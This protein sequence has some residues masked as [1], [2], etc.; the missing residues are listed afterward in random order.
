MSKYSDL[1]R[2]PRWQKRRLQ[3]FERD[4][5]ECNACGNKDRQLQVHHLKYHGKPWDAP[6]E[7]LETLCDECHEWRTEWDNKFGRSLVRT[8]FFKNLVKVMWWACKEDFEIINANPTSEIWQEL[9]SRWLE[10]VEK[11]KVDRLHRKP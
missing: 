10:R 6:D 11:D 9:R 4:D 1:L 7:H 5:W 8:L 2:D 3:V